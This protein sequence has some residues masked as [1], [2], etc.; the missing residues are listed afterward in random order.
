MLLLENMGRNE[1]GLWYFASH[2][3]D[4][5]NQGTCRDVIYWSKRPARNDR[6]VPHMQTRLIHA[7]MSVLGREGSSVTGSF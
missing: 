3:Q 6:N 7:A 1:L 4:T 5:R 2:M